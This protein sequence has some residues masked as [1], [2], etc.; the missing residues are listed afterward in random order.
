MRLPG[1]KLRKEAFRVDST[2][3]EVELRVTDE[4]KFFGEVDD[5]KFERD[6]LADW[7]KAVQAHLE[8]T[9]RLTWDPVIVIEYRDAEQRTRFHE[10]QAH[11]EEVELAFSAAW[12]SRE[13]T[14]YTRTWRNVETRTRR[15]ANGHVDPDT[16]EIE[17]LSDHERRS[18][19]STGENDHDFVPFTPDRWRRLIAIAK[20]L[21]EVRVR[22]ASVLK[23]S[24]GA[25]LDALGDG[26]LITGTGTKLLTKGNRR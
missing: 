16:G 13:T 6:T 8:Q 25:K 1:K 18:A 14:L 22:I 17:P 21:V 10:N 2:N 24:T 9:R 5:A 23:D 26:N 19:S 11:R 7:R 12:Q 4:G 15:R 3:I 20:A